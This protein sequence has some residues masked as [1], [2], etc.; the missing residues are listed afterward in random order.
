MGK[1]TPVL[2]GHNQIRNQNGLTIG[3]I[4]FFKSSR[5]EY[6]IVSKDGC[7]PEAI[8]PNDA[9]GLDMCGKC[10]TKQTI[11]ANT[12][13]D[14]VGNIGISDAIH[15]NLCLE[16]IMSDDTKESTLQS[17]S[18]DNEFFAENEQY[19]AEDRGN[20]EDISKDLTVSANTSAN[21]GAAIVSTKDCFVVK[22][23]FNEVTCLISQYQTSQQENISQS[24]TLEKGIQQLSECLPSSSDNE[25][26]P[27]G[28]DETSNSSDARGLEL[29]DLNSLQELC[30]TD[31]RTAYITLDIIREIPD[32]PA[33][34][35]TKN[36]ESSKEYDEHCIA[37]M[38]GIPESSQASETG[39]YCIKIEDQVTDFS[40]E[41]KIDFQAQTKLQSPSTLSNP[42]I[43]ELKDN[44]YIKE[45]PLFQSAD[46]SNTSETLCTMTNGSAAEEKDEKTA[47]E[48]NTFNYPVIPSNMVTL[49]EGKTISKN[50]GS[51]LP[52]VNSNFSFKAPLKSSVENKIPDNQSKEILGSSLQQTS[53]IL[54]KQGKPKV[55]GPNFKHH[56]EVCT[57]LSYF[58]HTKLCCLC[59]FYIYFVIIVFLFGCPRIIMI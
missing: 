58:I 7:A 59:F 51:I 40:K 3:V 34:V 29:V 21:T 38:E 57:F 55:D 46:N 33:T 4:H 30:E 52:K 39:I 43:E 28:S 32:S 23:P 37:Q 12:D 11:D 54:F 1:S 20:T 35:N 42:I 22:D 27:L 13:I 17:D 41:G 8:L 16:A 49:N 6:S 2:S 45:N 31:K 10:P 9:N 14:V 26:I 5:N 48:R 53:R 24:N 44:T 15:S 19:S 47:S 56:T 25:E 18:L 50:D 36:I